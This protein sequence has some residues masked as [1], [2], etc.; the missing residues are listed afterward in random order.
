MNAS[1]AG[2]L[3]TQ[4]RVVRADFEQSVTS[5]S[6]LPHDQLVEVAFVGR[7]NAGKSSLLNALCR[8]R[9]LARVSK[10][11]G[12]TQAINLFSVKMAQGVGGEQ[13]VIRF[14]DLP[15]YGYAKVSAQVQRQWTQLLT[16]YLQS[17]DTLQ[18][19][20]VVHDIRREISAEESWFFEFGIAPALVALS[21]AD[22]VNR[23]ERN[24]ARAKVA[25]ALACP[26]D[27]VIA[28]SSQ[29]F[30]DPGLAELANAI[31]HASGA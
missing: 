7:S 4:W 24:A 31:A 14:A 25:R 12:R 18:L 29:E 16:D 1:S 13:S 17:R 27:S 9:A 5:L 21:K 2:E 11:P 3:D 6:Q 23:S 22:K 10:T 19:I 26:A 15:G 20:I 28:I 8:Q 30:S